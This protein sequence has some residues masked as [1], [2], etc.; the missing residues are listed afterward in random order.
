[1]NEKTE[2]GGGFSFI[3]GVWKRRKW[4][5]ILVFAAMFSFAAGMAVFL[6]NVYRSTATIL[7]E[8]QLVSE[9]FVKSSVLGDPE[10][11]LQ[12]ISQKVLS[13]TRLENLINRFALYP[14]SRGKAPVEEVVEQAR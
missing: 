3:L 2:K 12:T 8:N 10:T 6:P 7:V 13:R 11:R 1:M 14:N 4:L 5:A 9:T